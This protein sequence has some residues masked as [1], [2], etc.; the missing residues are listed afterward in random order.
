M[1]YFK[2]AKISENISAVIIGLICNIFGNMPNL[3]NLSFSDWLDTKTW[4]NTHTSTWQE[5][6]SIPPPPSTPPPPP[7]LPPTPPPP[8]FHL[9]PHWLNSDRCIFLFFFH[10]VLHFLNETRKIKKS[11]TRFRWKNRY[12]SIQC[13]KRFDQRSKVVRI[14]RLEMLALRGGCTAE[15]SRQL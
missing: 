12:L 11:M 4:F 8:F 7:L 3:V 10:S 2:A 9:P 1:G 13:N 6:E 15:C 5:P 14:S